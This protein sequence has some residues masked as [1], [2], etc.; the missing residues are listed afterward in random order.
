MLI[1][2]GLYKPRYGLYE[3]GKLDKKIILPVTMFLYIFYQ[4]QALTIQ[5]M[6]FCVFRLYCTL[7][8]GP[9]RNVSLNI[10][11][12]YV[13]SW[14]FS[15]M[16]IPQDLQLTKSFQDTFGCDI[17][18]VCVFTSSL[19]NSISLLQLLSLIFNLTCSWVTNSFEG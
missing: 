16:K 13:F 9:H 5:V 19:N 7:Y 6:S 17:I 12:Y 11:Y 15:L 18:C 3:N 2:I 4:H 8:S 1:F 14:P 10:L